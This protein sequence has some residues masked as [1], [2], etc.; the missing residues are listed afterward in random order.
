MAYGWEAYLAEIDDHAVS[1]VLDLDA[2]LN[3]ADQKTPFVCQ[4]N[5]GLN[6]PESDGLHD[7][8]ENPGLDKFEDL[9]EEAV[10]NQLKGKYVGRCTGKGKRAFYSYLPKSTGIKEFME[11]V[12]QPC[13]EYTAEV[14]ISYDPEWSYYFEGLFPSPE[15]LRCIL[16]EQVIR[17]LEE[18][19]DA[20]ESPREVDHWIYFPSEA[21][22]ET[23]KNDVE[24]KGF[25]ICDE[26]KE[27][28]GQFPYCLHISRHDSVDRDSI[29]D[30][31]LDLFRKAEELEG[32]YDGWETYVVEE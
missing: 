9:F 4:V 16:N 28:E 23:Y 18:K 6:H 21:A 31:I 22:M 32:D 17:E 29:H 26:V 25:K 7:P 24:A 30:L 3:F 19:G 12:L 14:K 1:I 10:Q 27:G 11:K 2:G 5:I 8:S 20:L 13:S 15:E